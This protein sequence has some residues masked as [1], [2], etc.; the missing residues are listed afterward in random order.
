LILLLHNNFGY[1][2]I[3]SYMVSKNIPPLGVDL[4][5]PDFIGLGKAYG[6]ETHA[7][8]SL[9]DL[10]SAVQNAAK[11]SEPTMILFGDEIRGQ[12][13]AMA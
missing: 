5:T 4:Y 1:G 2:E 12:A 11:S 6:W 3:K 8:T 7:A 9:D 13:Q 10:F